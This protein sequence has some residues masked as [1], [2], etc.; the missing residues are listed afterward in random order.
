M[1]IKNILYIYGETSKDMTFYLS[2]Y[3]TLCSR[4]VQV[5]GAQLLQISWVIW[6]VFKFNKKF[7]KI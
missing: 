6:I 3:I 4:L 2:E 1:R 5:R 7:K